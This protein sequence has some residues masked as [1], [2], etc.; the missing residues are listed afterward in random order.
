MT[1]ALTL[2]CDHFADWETALINATGRGFYGFDCRYA[3]PKGA[4]VT[5][6]GGLRVTPDLAL[7]DI[8][9][10]EVDL[11]MICGGT[12]WQSDKAPDIGDLLRAAQARNIVIAGICDGTRELARA[13]L[14]D[15]RRHTSNSAENL[16]AVGY[17]GAAHYQDVPH[18]VADQRVITAPGSAPVSFMAQILATLGISD[19]NLTAYL[20]MHA[21]EHQQKS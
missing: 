3:S 9:L 7:E 12:L 5:S 1:R 14:L 13:G 10:D 11:L 21:A 8:R 16:L 6:M 17:G 2:I 19:D 18:A 4:V 20:G 15:H